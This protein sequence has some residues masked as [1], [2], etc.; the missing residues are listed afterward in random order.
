[1]F[2]P[3][4]L[5]ACYLSDS[6]FP[7]LLKK[8]PDF[9]SAFRAALS[10]M[11]RTLSAASRTAAS[12]RSE[13]FKPSF[14]ALMPTAKTANHAISGFY[15]A[16]YVRSKGPVILAMAILIENRWVVPGEAVML[17]GGLETVEAHERDWCLTSNIGAI[18]DTA[19][20]ILDLGGQGVID[21]V[22]G[23]GG[24]ALHSGADVICHIP[25]G[26]D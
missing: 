13:A 2:R 22:F 5:A 6:Q 20:S 12:E 23:G 24:G 11:C 16:S 19:S 1:M 10:L 21:F 9:L 26:G 3:N 15:L 17:F 25:C 8:P 7:M 18:A 14:S 4:Q